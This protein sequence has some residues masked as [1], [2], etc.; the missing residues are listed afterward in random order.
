M[1]TIS[2]K[3]WV[4]RADFLVQKKIMP[5]Y[6]EF[7]I[8]DEVPI[9]PVARMKFYAIEPNQYIVWSGLDNENAFTWAL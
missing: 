5:E 6:Q 1:A 4:A 2:W 9:S 3:I 8:G 7:K